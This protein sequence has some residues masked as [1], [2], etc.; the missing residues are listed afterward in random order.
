VIPLRDDN[1]TRH[2]PF[3]TLAIIALNVIVFL[4]WQPTFGSEQEQEI[5]WF[6]HAEIPWEVTHQTSLG[7][8]GDEAARAIANQFD[9]SLAQ[10]R[11]D[12]ALL[13]REC[14]G[15]SWWA[16]VFV[17]MF[18]HANWLHIGGNMLFLWVFGNNVEDKLRP[19]LFVLFYLGAGL[20][21]AAAQ[22]AAAPDSVIPNLGAS[23][24]IAGVL[25]AYLVMFPRR[26]VLTLVIFFFITVVSLPA[27]VVLGFWFVLQVVSGL[28]EL[29]QRVGVG[30]GIAFWAHVGGFVFGVGL[31]LLFFP[32]ERIRQRPPPRRP[33]VERG[34]ARWRSLRGGSVPPPTWQGRP[35]AGQPSAGPP[36]AGPPTRPD[37][38]DPWSLPPG[39]DQG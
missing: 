33:D 2:V 7:D 21:A 11:A 23:G 20:A 4:F 28:L 5:F 15:K 25:G 22:I 29:G 39:G 37:A 1:P 19:I 10:A 6:C 9:E 3:V 31:A 30:S 12:Q 17:A 16:S 8:G 27:V 13:K 26:R 14:G 18:L 34:R 38:R 36:E 24:A 32:K 35:D